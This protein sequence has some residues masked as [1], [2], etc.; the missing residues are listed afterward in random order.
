[1]SVGVKRFIKIWITSLILFCL[2][3]AFAAQIANLPSTVF[4]SRVQQSLTDKKPDLALKPTRLSPSDKTGSNA[5]MMANAQK[6]FF[7]LKKIILIGNHVYS[8]QE[9]SVL[10]QD[11]LNKRISLAELIEIV[12]KISNYYRSHGYIISRA[13]LPPQTIANG[14]VTIQVIEGYISKVDVIGHPYGARALVQAYGDHM[15]ADK[16]IRL[17]TLEH[18]IQLA[19]EIPGTTVRSVLKPSKTTPAASDIDLYTETQTAVA[20]VSYD[21]YGTRYIGPQE[22]TISTAFNSIFRS[23]DATGLTLTGSSNLQ[24]LRSASVVHDTPIG[25]EGKRF[26]LGGNYTETRPGFILAP[27]ELIGRA[28]NAYATFRFPV[29]RSLTEELT[30]AGAFNYIDSGTN[31]AIGKLY[32]DKIRSLELNAIY[33]L[34]D[35]HSGNNQILFNLSKG[36]PVLGASPSGELTGVS[37]AGGR[38]DYTKVNMQAVRLQGVTDRL[39]IYLLAMGQYSFNSLLVPVQFGYGGSQVGRGYDPS[40]IIGD[41]GL[42]GSI[43]LRFNTQPSFRLLQAMQYYA[44]YDIGKIWN[45]LTLNVPNNQSASSVGIGTRLQFTKNLSGNLFVAQP[46]TKQVA[47]LEIIGNGRSPRVFFSVSL[48]TD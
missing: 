16:P 37:R 47:A 21:N 48:G 7:T 13:V 34:A 3:T 27:L 35:R 12:D 9:L 2:T 45:I 39:S 23:G 29:I 26:A 8:D 25:T 15:A 5:T 42:S 40:E 46:L 17:S 6:L 14:T 18:Y 41:R 11:K 36:L 19:N 30:F 43:E 10:Y 24:A 4:P 1:M 38:T 33:Q 44:F 32:L 20:N 31:A 22:T 28:K